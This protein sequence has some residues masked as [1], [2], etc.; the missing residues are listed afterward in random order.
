MSFGDRLV[1][2]CEQAGLTTYALAKKTGMSRQN[3]GRLVR[4]DVRPTWDTVQKLA[5]VLGVECTAFA[6]R[7]EL[8]DVELRQ[9]GRPKKA[10][11]AAEAKGKGKRK[12]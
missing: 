11:A 3:I 2:L 7:Q 10:P 8:P 6:E 12:R 4:G 1:E 5:Q 9:P